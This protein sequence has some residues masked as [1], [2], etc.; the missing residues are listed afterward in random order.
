MASAINDRGQIVVNVNQADG[1]FH[2]LLVNPGGTVF[3][4]LGKGTY[5]NDLNDL[6]QVVGSL[7]GHAI[8]YDRGRVQDLGTGAASDINNF[9]VIAG[10]GSG[11]GFVY[12]PGVGRRNL[13]DLTPGIF[14]NH[15]DATGAG[16]FEGYLITG[17]VGINDRGQI[18][19]NADFFFLG[20]QQAHERAVILTP[21]FSK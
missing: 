9:G 11:S 12:F 3:Q 13:Q 19:A 5:A 18:A 6:G 14:T 15:S 16:P 4:N 1:N 17:A 8:L 2:A 20:D 21:H 10:G 7:N